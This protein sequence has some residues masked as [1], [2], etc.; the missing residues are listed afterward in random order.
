MLCQNRGSSG[1]T[2]HVQV[3]RVRILMATKMIRK[4]SRERGWGGVGG[5]Y[6]S[7]L[8]YLLL[9][10]E[11]LGSIPSIPQKIQRKKLSMLLR[12]ING[13]A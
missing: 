11:A 1:L 7:W 12:L 9:D 2:T 6:S 10:S 4:E 13:A 8:A 3:T 5:Q